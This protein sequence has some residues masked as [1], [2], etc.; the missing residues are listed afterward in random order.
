MTG[1]SESNNDDKNTSLTVTV[2]DEEF[3]EA[4][5]SLLDILQECQFADCDYGRDRDRDVKRALTP[6]SDDSTGIGM[7]DKEE[8]NNTNTNTNTNLGSNQFVDEKKRA[9]GG[10]SIDVNA[11]EISAE[12]FES[13]SLSVRG[14]CKIGDVQQVLTR[15]L[16]YYTTHISS[17]S[18]KKWT[19]N[20]FIN[21]PPLS[22][23]DL[24]LSGCT[25]AGKTGD[26]VVGTLRS[27]GL[28]KIGKPN[29]PGLLLTDFMIQKLLRV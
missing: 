15:L 3:S 5:E 6:Q 19:L 27:L 17:S 22:T 24:T 1:D 29:R 26:C 12:Q 14:R 23:S 25:V 4:K 16:T 7:K 2:V 13:V 9:E 28:I 11:F 20:S 21:L 8:I 10:V 18:S